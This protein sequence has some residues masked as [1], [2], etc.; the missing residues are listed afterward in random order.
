MSTPSGER[1]PL[2]IGT[3]EREAA[4]A[5]LSAHLEAGR[6]DAEEYGERYGRASV[7]RTRP[8]LEVLF[9][10]LP[11]P[12]PQWADAAPDPYNPSWATRGPR[13]RRSRPLLSGWRMVPAVFLLLPLAAL[14]VAATTGFWFLFVVIPLTA[15]FIGRRFGR[16]YGYRGYGR[17]G[18]CGWVR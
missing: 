7:A 6:L 10:D 4:Y 9:V 1:P 8:D 3:S 13:D 16:G 12:H 14:F 18:P 17:R 2:R 5:A 11:A 15:S